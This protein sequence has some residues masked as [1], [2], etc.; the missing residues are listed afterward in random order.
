VTPGRAPSATYEE[1]TTPVG[2]TATSDNQYGWLE[3]AVPAPPTTPAGK[4]GLQLTVSPSQVSSKLH[5]PSSSA[6]ASG[7]MR[8]EPQ[9]TTLI[10]NALYDV[11]NYRQ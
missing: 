1:V 7:P 6:A 8:H 2:M 5:K 10:D 4:Y 3:I 9:A 11:C